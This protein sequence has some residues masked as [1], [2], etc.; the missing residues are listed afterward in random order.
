MIKKFWYYKTKKI[1]ARSGWGM[2]RNIDIRYR[3]SARVALAAIAVLIGTLL[4]LPCWAEVFDL[5]GMSV[6][7]AD[8]GTANYSSAMKVLAILTVLSLAP[9]ILIAMTAFTRI[10]IGRA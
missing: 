1:T 9:A 7:L 3:F 10:K 2:T 4:A 5:P 8:E 6:Q